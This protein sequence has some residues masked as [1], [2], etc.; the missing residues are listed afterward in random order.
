MKFN[1]VQSLN[2]AVFVKSYSVQAIARK[3]NMMM[4]AIQLNDNEFMNWVRDRMYRLAQ[5]NSLSIK[6]LK[7]D[8]ITGGFIE[9]EKVLRQGDK[10]FD[11][12]S[13]QFVTYSQK[14]IRFASKI[15]K[16]NIVNPEPGKLKPSE[17]EVAPI[18]P[19]MIKHQI[20]DNV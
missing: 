3:R 2:E 4:N 6:D 19:K 1:S 16:D 17:D 9:W 15:I 8:Y 13:E 18:S 11:Q 10:D 14:F 12:Y 5:Q 7:L 20:S